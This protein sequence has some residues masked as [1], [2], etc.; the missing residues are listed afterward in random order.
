MIVMTNLILLIGA[1]LFSRAI[2]EFEAHAFAQIVGADVDDTGGD[3]P[4]SFD[5]RNSVWHLD[6]C[7]PENNFDNGGWMIF[8]AIFGWTNSATYGSVSGYVAY[9][10]AVMIALVGL[11]WKEGRMTVFGKE[12]K[13]ARERR[14]RREKAAVEGE[15]EREAEHE[16]ERSIESSSA[17]APETPGVEELPK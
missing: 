12:S 5:V 17:K 11:K 6:C 9:W 10:V 16:K 14:E 3:G 15:G 8:N 1:G 7:N 13:I 2:W 4:G